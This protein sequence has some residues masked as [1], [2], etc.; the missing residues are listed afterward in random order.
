MINTSSNR[1]ERILSV[2]FVPISK[3]LIRNSI[4]LPSTVEHLKRSLVQAAIEGGATTDSLI[5]LQTGVHRK[6]VK[7]LRELSE[8]KMPGKY[9]IKGL[10]IVL[11]TWSNDDRFCDSSGKPRPLPRAGTNGFDD[12]VRVCKIDLAPATV[13]QELQSQNLISQED[14]GEITLLSPTFVAQTGEAALKAFEA[15]ITDHI[16]VAIDNVLSPQGAPRKFDR[17]VR[18]S[19]LSATSVAKLEAEADKLAQAYLEH[20]NAIAHRLQSEDDA[21]GRL[22]G[23]RFVTGVYVAANPVEPGTAP[24]QKVNSQ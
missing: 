2:I 23:G 4:P 5:S 24:A 1:V 8:N 15:T 13:M 12:L 20:M 16:R 22:S 10:A 6:D 17:V 21:S 11:S 18:Y 9:P 7:R 14:D 3:L 19:H